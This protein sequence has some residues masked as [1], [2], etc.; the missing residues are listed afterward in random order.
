VLFDPIPHR[1][2]LFDRH[3]AVPLFGV[4]VHE[5]DLADVDS[6]IVL[7]TC[8]YGQLEPIADWLRRSKLPKLAVDHHITRDELADTY[9]VDESAAATCLILYE[10]AQAT[11][12]PMKPETREA[13]YVG[14]AMDTGW[15]RQ[16]NTDK[17][18]MAAAADLV[19]SGVQPH[20][21]FQEL[22][23]RE[24]P[25]RVR[26]LGV[27]LGTMELLSDDRL[28]VMTLAG[29][30]IAACGAVTADTE[31]IVNE[32]LRIGSVAVSVL[33]V[34]APD[35]VVRASFRSKPPLGIAVDHLE[36]DAPAGGAARGRPPDI[37][38]ARAAGAF[39]GGGHARA[40]G[41]RLP[42]SLMDAR[43][44]VV[45]HLQSTLAGAPTSIA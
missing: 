28:A 42:G 40:A 26:L 31:D 34:E 1:Y 27:A 2:A 5:T 29:E 32:P 16:S 36:A 6:V 17:R 19:A 20:S 12:W 4:D 11:R 22:F 37:D 10:W 41:A 13:L 21:L 18:V 8:A 35:G 38:V 7:D 30:S 39:G 45:G 33:L 15:F 9:V 43:R 14:M 24:S 3:P 23:Q 25:A 44:K